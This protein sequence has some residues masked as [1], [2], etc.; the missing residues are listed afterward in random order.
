M[1]DR[2]RAYRY[3]H[4]AEQLAALF[5]RAKGYRIAAKR[6]RNA[7]GEIDL[8]AV[9]GD[10][11]IAVEVKARQTLSECHDTVTPAKQQKIARAMQGL[12]AGHSKI[13][14]LADAASRNIR[15][16]VIWI[17]PWHWPRHIRDAWRM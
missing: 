1:A 2:R 15:F 8:V 9:K 4:Y 13:A 17:V 3:G 16:D 11:L 12:L 10:L 14:G 7:Q 6:Y 5:L